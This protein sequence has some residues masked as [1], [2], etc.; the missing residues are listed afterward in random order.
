MATHP[1]VLCTSCAEIEVG[2][3]KNGKKQIQSTTIVKP[4]LTNLDPGGII[5]TREKPNLNQLDSELI[6][7]GSP[8]TIVYGIPPLL[9]PFSAPKFQ[10]E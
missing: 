3:Y 2:R 4:F 7:N 1:P 6:S 9:K 5:W 10:K 8:L